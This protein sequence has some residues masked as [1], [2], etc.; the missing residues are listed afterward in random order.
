VHILVL[1]SLCSQLSIFCLFY[2][3]S[4]WPVLSRIP[5]SFPASHC[6]FC[7][8][9][10]MEKHNKELERK[11]RLL[12]HLQVM[13]DSATE[14]TA[15]CQAPFSSLSP[16]VCSS[17]CLLSQYC[18]LLLVVIDPVVNSQNTVLD[19][20]KVLWLSLETLWTSTSTMLS[21]AGWYRSP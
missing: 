4:M 1:S 10:M 17:S 20:N 2:M 8:V 13:S 21:Q 6:P 14:W 18:F 7:E 12:F 3:D 16:G 5:S 15:T 9:Y 19:H 11:L